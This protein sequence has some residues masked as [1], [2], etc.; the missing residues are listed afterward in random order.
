MRLRKKSAQ[1]GTRSISELI[2]SYRMEFIFQKLSTLIIQSLRKWEH[3][4]KESLREWKQMEKNRP[5]CPV[6]SSGPSAAAASGIANKPEVEWREK[7]FSFSCLGRHRT[8]HTLTHTHTRAFH[9][10]ESVVPSLPSLPSLHRALVEW[11]K[12]VY[13]LLSFPVPPS[14]ILYNL[15]AR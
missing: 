2:T 9:R 3:W 10:G 11:S 5:A 14:C 8:Q 7:G 13:M 15:A 1:V 6:N 12:S 4:E